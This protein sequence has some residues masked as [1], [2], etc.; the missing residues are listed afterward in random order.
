[1]KVDRV[2]IVF[3]YNGNGKYRDIF[4]EETFIISEDPNLTLGQLIEKFPEKLGSLEEPKQIKYQVKS[5][6]FHIG[7]GYRTI[8][9][10]IIMSQ[11]DA[12]K[13]IDQCYF[14]ECRPAESYVMELY[15]DTKLILYVMDIPNQEKINRVKKNFGR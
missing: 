15:P 11:E 8:K 6:L 12:Q 7:F 1:V 3:L 4:M 2:S 9:E 10:M 5:G 14:I 13:F